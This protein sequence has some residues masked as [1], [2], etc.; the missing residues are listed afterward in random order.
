[1][2][3]FLSF[4]SAAVL[5]LAVSLANAAT[6][7]IDFETLPAGDVQFGNFVLDGFVFSPECHYDVRNGATGNWLGFDR[8][9]GCVAGQN[10]D[11]LGPMDPARP[12]LMYVAAENGSTFSLLSLLPIAPGF[13]TVDSSSG[14]HLDAWTAPLEPDGTISLTGPGWDNIS[15]LV[16]HHDGGVPQGFDNLRL[17]SNE[18]P[19]PGTLSLALSGLFALSAVGRRVRPRPA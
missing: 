5:A 18:V 9:A 4:L 7:T 1:M 11:Y 8:G 3:R 2:M 16:F 17:S 13:F 14:G 19:L 10:P 6:V 12:G 15:W